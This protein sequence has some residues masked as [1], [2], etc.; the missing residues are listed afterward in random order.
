MGIEEYQ[1]L[2]NTLS[3]ISS[4]SIVLDSEKKVL[5]SRKDS[6][7]KKET[8]IGILEEQ[9]VLAEKSSGEE[10]GASRN[11]IAYE[12]KELKSKLRLDS[13][14]LAEMKEPS[15]ASFADS[16]ALRGTAKFVHFF[17]GWACVVMLILLPMLFF[18]ENYDF[19]CVTDGETA[20]PV[21]VLDGDED[22]RD[23]SDEWGDP[24]VAQHSRPADPTEAEIY[25]LDVFPEYERWNDYA[26]DFIFL[27]LILWAFVLYGV[28]IPRLLRAWATSPRH[29]NALATYDPEKYH[30]EIGKL[31]SEINSTESEIAGKDV[32]II[33]IKRNLRFINNNPKK[34][35]K[36]R[37]E[38]AKLEKQVDAK[39]KRVDELES[40]IEKKWDSIRHLIPYSEMLG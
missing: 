28:I 18:E 31:E 10:L 21:Q 20:Y 17:L 38:L 2:T 4:L 5:G 40:S 32:Q 19:Q 25:L 1:F 36:G 22:C 16:S 13:D 30:E 14:L 8:D 11:K 29:L 26:V 3:E 6:K 7:K 35:D 33:Q 39:M 15:I 27:S 23:G 24:D 37:S 12:M 9:L 34:I